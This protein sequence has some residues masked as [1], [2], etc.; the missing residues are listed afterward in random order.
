MCK[1]VFCTLFMLTSDCSKNKKL[2]DKTEKK[3][4]VC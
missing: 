1:S 3:I 2:C 4:Q